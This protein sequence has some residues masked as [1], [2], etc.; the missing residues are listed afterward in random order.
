MSAALNE[1]LIREVVEEV[2][3]RLGPATAAPAAKTECHCPKP[4]PV[5]AG[6]RPLG[7]FQEAGQA[8]EAAAAAF[9]QLRRGGVAAR[10]KAVQVVK[11]LAVAHAPEWGRVEL[12]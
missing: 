12:E 3:G 2:L 11:T 10:Q 5:A 4:R 1:Q 9:E 7:V 8:C 6:G